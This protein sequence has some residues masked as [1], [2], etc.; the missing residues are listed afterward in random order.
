VPR[1]ANW[2]ALSDGIGQYRASVA[3]H[4][5]VE[6]GTV[7]AQCRP[8]P[9][10]TPQDAE[11]TG[12][13]NLLDKLDIVLAK[14]QHPEI[15]KHHLLDAWGYLPIRKGRSLVASAAILVAEAERLA[16][17]DERRKGKLTASQVR[18]ARDSLID[19]AAAVADRILAR[20]ERAQK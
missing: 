6:R 1:V 8:Q 13:E 10:S 7:D 5:G 3:R 9:D 14:A 11:A 18:D 17:D 2:L 19:Q 12:R 16:T 4:L 20:L 15:I